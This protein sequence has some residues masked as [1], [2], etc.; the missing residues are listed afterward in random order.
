M[1]DRN[2]CFNFRNEE[3]E[4]KAIAN[5]ILVIHEDDDDDSMKIYIRNKGQWR[6]RLKRF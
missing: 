2:K 4:N 5:L 6:K 3:E 1:M